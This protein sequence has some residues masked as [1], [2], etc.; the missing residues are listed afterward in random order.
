MLLCAGDG[1]KGEL[2][3]KASF[4]DKKGVEQVIKNRMSITGRTFYQ[5]ATAKSQ[6]SAFN[7]KGLYIDKYN[8]PRQ[9]KCIK[10]AVELMSK[11][12]LAEFNNSTFYHAFSVN[13]KWSRNFYETTRTDLH[14][15]YAGDK[16][17]KNSKTISKK[18]KNIA[19]I[20]NDTKEEDD[21]IL[22]IR[23]ITEKIKNN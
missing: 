7:G 12:D 5:E 18:K 20:N 13:P 23:G 2:S 10:D 19:K 8:I 1:D 15:F 17:Y 11:E 6:F 3:H 4:R 22:Q 14:I 9:A 16:G 21:V